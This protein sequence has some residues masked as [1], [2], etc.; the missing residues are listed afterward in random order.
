MKNR[1]NILFIL[2]DQLS[3][4]APSYM[5]NSDIETRA[6]DSLAANGTLFEA[7]YCT[8]P[9]CTPSRGSMFT[10]LMPH[11]CGTTTNK[12]SIHAHLREQELGNILA[13][14]GYECIYLGYWGVPEGT[15]PEENDHGFRGM[16]PSNDNLLAEACADALKRRAESDPGNA[17]PFFLVASF[18]NPHNVCEYARNMHLPLG[19]IGDPPRVEECPNLPPNF[20][21]PPFEPEIIRVVQQ[22]NWNAYPNRDSSPEEWRRLRWG[23]YRIIEKVDREIGKIL[24]TIREYDLDDDTLIVFSSDHGEGHGAHRW[25]QKS[26]LYEEVVRVPLIV[27]PPGGQAGR[28][29][30]THLTSTGLD[31]FPTICDYAGVGPP[32]NLQGRSLRPLV[33]GRDP[34]DWRDAVFVETVLNGYGGGRAVRTDRYKYIVYDR[35]RYPEQLFD[36][37]TDP[38]EMVNLAVESRHREVLQEHRRLL[39]RHIG[40]T[41]DEFRF[42]GHICIDGS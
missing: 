27:R 30:R 31:I 12:L 33:D 17:K 14:S 21:I 39:F 22:H 26:I 36:M 10:G 41:K 15:M 9:L 4:F 29:N 25:N 19:P 40:L 16:T 8:Q 42:P 13:Q 18:Y 7:S 35:G 2:T 1:P 5:G 24:G 38:G 28:V 11:E 37:K 23:Y 20:G 32:A 34:E 6:I 3:A